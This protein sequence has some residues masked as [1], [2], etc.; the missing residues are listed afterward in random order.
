M[1]TICACL[2]CLAPLFKDGRS[3]KS[4][5]ASARSFLRLGSSAG[6]SKD[7][8]S[9]NKYGSSASSTQEKRVVVRCENC[10]RLMVDK[11]PSISDIRYGQHSVEKKPSI[12]DIRYGQRS[13]EKKPSY[14]EMR[15]GQVRPA[16]AVQT[17]IS[18]MDER[19][20]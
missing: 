11:K 16:I 3:T 6:R 5:F 13:M 15:Y 10:Q 9:A 7:Y 19:E 2:P 18:S 17:T 20:W 12:S 14:S 8:Y 4:L 1:G